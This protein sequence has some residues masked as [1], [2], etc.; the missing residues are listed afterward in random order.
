MILTNKNPDNHTIYI[1]LRV[2]LNYGDAEANYSNEQISEMIQ[3]L[4][5]CK[6]CDNWHLN[7]QVCGMDT[8]TLAGITSED[9]TDKTQ[10][11]EILQGMGI[12]IRRHPPRT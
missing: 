12:P 9:D 1:D 2:R 10:P 7:S 8:V 6:K 11:T 5:Q 4:M 3:D